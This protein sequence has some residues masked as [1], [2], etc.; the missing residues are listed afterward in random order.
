M[1]E[2]WAAKTEWDALEY[3]MSY[4]IN[5]KSFRIS[6]LLFILILLFTLVFLQ[7]LSRTGPWLGLDH[8]GWPGQATQ[9]GQ[10]MTAIDHQEIPSNACPIQSG[11]SHSW[12]R[13]PEAIRKNYSGSR[14]AYIFK[15]ILIVESA[16]GRVYSRTAIFQSFA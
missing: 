2:R 12:P 6:T 16:V 14:L 15:S 10:T 7:P 4:R 9:I 3:S 13:P 1:F 5:T 11:L 8:F